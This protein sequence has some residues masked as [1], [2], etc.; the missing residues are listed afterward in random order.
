[1][2]QFEREPQNN[3]HNYHYD[4]Y[5]LH[6]NMLSPL[7]ALLYPYLTYYILTLPFFFIIIKVLF[8]IGVYLINNDVLVTGIQQSDS[9]IPIQVS[10]LFQILFPFK[11]LQNIE[12]SSLCYTVGPCWLSILN[13]VVCTSQ[14]QTPNLSL[15]SPCPFPMPW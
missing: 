13:I 12:P 14:S 6:S 1:M 11:L 2:N 8:Y 3:Y 10:I 4:S 7:C 9:V 5:H 15:P